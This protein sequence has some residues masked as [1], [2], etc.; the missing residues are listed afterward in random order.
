L[1]GPLGADKYATTEEGLATY[2][3]QE[4]A[5]ARGREP[6]NAGLRGTLAI[7]A[8]MDGRN[9]RETYQFLRGLGYSEDKAWHG[10]SRAFRGVADT[11]KKDGNVCT[12]DW[13][14]RIGN[15]GV[16]DFVHTKGEAEL[17]RLWVGKVG[18]HHLGILSE[19]G[20]TQPAIKRRYLRIEHLMPELFST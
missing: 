6:K 8:A 11:S 19:L 13:T 20:I 7:G 15:I 14:Y 18:I 12:F 5:T 2:S 9:F 10:T 3:E 1:I 4:V 17:D 16:W